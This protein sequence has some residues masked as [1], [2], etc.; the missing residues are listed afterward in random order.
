MT[1]DLVRTVASVFRR[2]GASDLSTAEFKH[3]LSLDLRW[4]APADA[5][6]LLAHAVNTGLVEEQGERVAALFDVARVDVPVAFR[7]TLDVL[8]EAPPALPSRLALPPAALPAARPASAPGSDPASAPAPAPLARAQASALG[9]L[10]EA[11]SAAA[12]ASGLDRAD[13][14]K[15][16]EDERVRRGGLFSADVAALVVARRRGVDVR[17]LA[18]RLR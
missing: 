10:E 14:E 1:S 7:P 15:E 17:A 4:F 3:A 8:D 13:V 6:K 5:R 16:V 2:K 9:V 11:V 18:A 12:R